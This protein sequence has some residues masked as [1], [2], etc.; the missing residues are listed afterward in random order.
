VTAWATG[1]ESA[2]R[3]AELLQ[4]DQIGRAVTPDARRL[5]IPRTE[6]GIADR[7]TM[8]RWAAK[9][10][11]VD[12]GPRVQDIAGWLRPDDAAKL[13]E[14]AR[15]AEGSILEI[16]T[17]RGKSTVLMA[18]GLVDGG[19][20]GPIFTLDVDRQSLGLAADAAREHGLARYIVFVHGTVRA[21]ARAHPH[22][23][24]SFV[25]IDGDHSLEGVRGDLVVLAQVVP[26]GARL[27]FHDFA[28][29]RNQ[30]PAWPDTKVRPAVDASW[31][32][33]DCDFVGT[34][35]VCGLYIRRTGPETVG[36]AIAEL[37]P[38][39]RAKDQYVHRIRNPA[40][41]RLRRLTRRG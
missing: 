36:P 5:S 2:W 37:M 15:D 26:V 6:S 41:R 20:T 11:R 29:P 31:V 33:R 12:A 21:F 38:L 30:D 35:G 18:R 34:F 14:L 7:H 23:R 40:I 4:L 1:E 32:A 22:V 17:Y 28:D 9:V 13:Y 39:E 27:L 8:V 10:R 16:G 3:L 25:F 24:P 19:H